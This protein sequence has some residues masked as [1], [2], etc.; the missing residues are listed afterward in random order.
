[1]PLIDTVTSPQGYLP[2][3]WLFNV[4]FEDKANQKSNIFWFISRSALIHFTA[5]PLPFYICV[6]F[7]YHKTEFLTGRQYIKARANKAGTFI[8][9]ITNLIT[10]PFQLL[11]NTKQS[12]REEA[13]SLHYRTHTLLLKSSTLK[14]YEIF[15]APWKNFFRRGLLV[16]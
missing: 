1:M 5:F 12:G 2:S 15:P 7:V 10:T 8:T 13:R 6:L 11:F 9:I 14:L 3:A 16:Q 4:H